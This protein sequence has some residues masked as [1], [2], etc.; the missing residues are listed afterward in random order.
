MIRLLFAIAF[1]TTTSLFAQE[2]LLSLLGEES[3]GVE[4][5][6]ASFKATRVINGHS[7]ENTAHG[8]LDF[9]I[10]HRMGFVN[11]G[12]GQLFGLDQ[13]TIRL[14][15]DYGVTD[16]LMIGLGRSS[17]QKTLDGFVKYKLLR[18]CEQGCGMP[19][20]LGL[21][22]STSATTLEA[23]QVPWFGEGREDY[24]THRLSY[25]FQAVVGRKFS[26]TFTLQASPGVVHRNLVATDEDRNDL[27]NVG[28]AGRVKLSR[29][30][31]LNAEYFYVLPGQGPREAFHNAMAIGFDIETGGHVF[32]LHFT[33]STG[34]FERGF[35]T[36][37]V[38]D[39][40]AGDIHFGFN[41]SRVF[42][43][44]DPRAK[45]RRKQQEAAGGQG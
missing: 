20:T 19:L 6:T 38:G 10:G 21:V 14:G 34:M 27:I 23:D 40:F 29:R 33:N 11:S 31:T 39:F 37:T 4:Y 45:A 30:V 5:T 7:L 28:M 18:Q 41:I 26:E 43:L 35:I 12:L 13:A 36:E 16:R 3:A 9:R 8:V 22:A 2:D 25:S 24:F 44:H 15:F 17:Y 32:Q 42:T 1:C